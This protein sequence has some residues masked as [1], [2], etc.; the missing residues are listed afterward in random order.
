MK[1]P[2]SLSLLFLFCAVLV[3][4]QTAAETERLLDAK[5][6]TCA[7]AAWFVL[8]SAPGDPLRDLPWEIPRDR[9]AAFSLAMERGWLPKKAESGD[10]ITLGGVSLLIMKTFDIKGGLMYRFFPGP[11]YAYREMT[12]QGF[13][14]GRAYPGLKV[15]GER[16]LRILGKALS[17]SGTE[18]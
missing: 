14:E 4:G 18:G 7:D 10:G 6:I 3:R 9:D 2:L 11:R 1:I 12:S 16:F 8:S 13:I 5:E 17:A 15:S